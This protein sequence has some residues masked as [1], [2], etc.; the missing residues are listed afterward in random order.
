MQIRHFIF[1]DEIFTRRLDILF[2]KTKSSRAVQ[3]FYFWTSYRS[4][5]ICDLKSKTILICQRIETL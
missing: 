1:G 4:M 2:L 5:K 3:T